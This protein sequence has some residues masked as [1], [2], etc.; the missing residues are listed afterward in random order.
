MNVLFAESTTSG[1]FFLSLSQNHCNALLRLYKNGLESKR[2]DYLWSHD[3]G[4][5]K[6]LE[7]RGLVLWKR[8]ASGLACGMEGLTEAGKLVAQLLVEAGMT[9]ENTL[10][11]RVKARLAGAPEHASA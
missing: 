11:P 4:T 3:V 10:S 9:L 5:F 8:D 7:N 6:G 2:G 1:A